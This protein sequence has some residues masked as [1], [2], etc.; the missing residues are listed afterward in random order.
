MAVDRHIDLPRRTIQYA[1][2]KLCDNQFIQR[3]GRGG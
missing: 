3:L 1:L 2:K